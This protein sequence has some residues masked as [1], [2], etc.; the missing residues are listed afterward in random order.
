[1][2]R[3]LFTGERL[4]EGQGLFAVDLLRHRA[5]YAYA[6]AFADA[7]TDPRILDLGC[8]TG[9]GTTQLAGTMPRVFAI[10]RIAPDPEN[11]RP[12]AEFIRADARA[13]PLARE[14]FDLVVSFQVIEHLDPPD[15]Y[16]R[17]IF[18]CLKPG[19]SAIISTPNRLESD[20]ENPFHVH[21]YEC[22][23]LSTLLESHFDSVDML[24]VGTTPASSAYFEARLRR[25]QSI[26][27]LDPLGLRRILPR[28][29]IHWLFGR[30]A[31]LVRR[32][33]P[34]RGGSIEIGPQDFP[35]GKASSDCLD[36]LALCRKH[37]QRGGEEKVA[38]RGREPR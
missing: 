36:L 15:P 14:S 17:T 22:Q 19:G 5:A 24:G 3:T 38:S 12:N 11:R 26:V 1:M 23:E 16:L 21:E 37:E 9:Y 4:H 8:G 34:A 25:I 6:I 30:L 32:T 13:L 31:I 18:D 2:S 10:D 27:R 7:W 20:G 29:L 35:I 33:I 28:S